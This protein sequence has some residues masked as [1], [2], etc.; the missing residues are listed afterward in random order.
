MRCTKFLLSLVA[1]FATIVVKAQTLPNMGSA[2]NFGILSGGYFNADDTVIVKGVAGIA[3]GNL[4]IIKAVNRISSGTVLTTALNDLNAAKN[5]LSSQNGTLVSNNLNGQVLS[6][7]VYSISGNASLSSSLELTGDSNSVFIFNIDGDLAFGNG[8]RLILQKQI[9]TSKIYWNVNGNITFTSNTQMAG[10]CLANGSISVSGIFQG[11]CGLLTASSLSI[12]NSGASSIS[13]IFQTGQQIYYPQNSPAKT[14]NVFP[15]NDPNCPA[16]PD[17]CN[18]IA[19]PSFE[20]IRPFVNL[21][22][23]PD[24]DNQIDYACNWNKYYNSVGNGYMSQIAPNNIGF[25]YN[26]QAELFATCNGSDWGVPFNKYCYPGTATSPAALQPAHNGGDNYAG[27]EFAKYYGSIV[28]PFSEGD[29]PP[30]YTGDIIKDEKIEK[31]LGFNLVPS[32]AYYMEFYAS[33]SPISN[34]TTKIGV[35]PIHNGSD[36]LSPS[37]PFHYDTPNPTAFFHSASNITY[38]TNWTKVSGCVTTSSSDIG[39]LSIRAFTDDGIVPVTSMDPLVPAY[40]P[41]AFS[42]YFFIDDVTLRP[43]ADA[44][45]DQT[46]TCNNTAIIGGNCAP[47]VGATYVWTASN[48]FTA[49]NSTISSPNANTSNVIFTAPGTFVYDVTVTY[50]GC[51]ATDQ[52]VITV[53][54]LG[55]SANITNINLGCL[56]TQLSVT[57]PVTGAVYTWQPGGFTGTSITV[58][59]SSPTVYTLYA[60]TPGCANTSNVTVNPF[61]NT[62][63]CVNGNTS[64]TNITIPV[65]TNFTANTTYNNTNFTCLGSI[66]VPLGAN[67][68]FN[69]CTFMMGPNTAIDIKGKATVKITNSHF[70]GC[71]DLWKGILMP[72]QIGANLTITGSVIEDAVWGVRVAAA[73]SNISAN[74]PNKLT[75]DNSIFN[76]NKTDIDYANDNTNNL[77]V[78]NSVFT[79][80]CLNF[81]PSIT[82]LP[83]ISSSFFITQI[84]SQPVAYLIGTTNAS[85]IYGIYMYEYGNIPGNGTQIDLKTFNVFDNHQIGIHTLNFHNLRIEKQFF[86]NGVLT[87]ETPFSSTGIYVTNS[88][89]IPTSTNPNNNFF[90]G[91]GAGGGKGNRFQN[92]FYGIYVTAPNK[93][94]IRTNIGYN[95]FSKMDRAGIFYSGVPYNG[96]VQFMGSHVI[97]ANSFFN[98]TNHAISV[99]NSGKTGMLITNNTI[100]NPTG[101]SIPYKG[102]NIS[103]ISNPS[104]AKYNIAGN[105]LTNVNQGIIASNV[106]GININ[107]NNIS[108]IQGSTFPVFNFALGI[109]LKNCSKPAVRA[110][111]IT[112]LTIGGAP[113]LDMGI[114]VSDCPQ[115]VYTCNTLRY[116][117]AGTN[118]NGQNLSTK[119]SQNTYDDNIIGIYLANNGF[120]DVQGNSSSSGAADNKF[121]NMPTGA[122][123]SYAASVGAVTTNG[124]LSPFFIRNSPQFNMTNNGAS[125]SP[126]SLPVQVNY[127]VSPSPYINSCVG[128]NSGSVNLMA[129]GFSP[130]ADKVANPGLYAISLL[131]ENHTSK[132][133]L[134]EQLV[135]TTATPN[136]TLQAFKA[137]NANGTLNDIAMVDSTISEHFDGDTTA[138]QKAQNHNTFTAANNVE[139][140]QKDFNNLY[141]RYLKTKNLNSTE[142]SQLK[143]IA[144]RCPFSDGTAV[145]QARA[146]MRLMDD[147]MEYD[148]TCE[149]IDPSDVVLMTARKANEAGAELG[150]KQNIRVELMPNPNNGEFTL[151]LNTVMD[152]LQVIVIDVNGKVVCDNKQHQAD[153]L[154][155]S[156]N[157]LA[158][159]LY[160]LKVF[161]NGNYLQTKKLL[162]QK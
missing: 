98:C 80:R 5:F 117:L 55:A 43:L 39:F 116:L 73:G 110:N 115:G 6:A 121:I 107:S 133:Q 157:S 159:G 41:N 42:A 24:N 45:L 141:L 63:N 58:N 135:N 129:G 62:T 104:N 113:K 162:I 38:N 82:P 151:L 125:T 9:R 148:N 56:G 108:L 156:C 111:D 48:A 152:E 72:G 149:R 29:E 86:I 28:N 60:S 16:V 22:N 161:G 89:F 1:V 137:A 10:L 92:L 59:P 96:S 85:P 158:N 119:L 15:D 112:G 52:V 145:W 126:P 90:V 128:N 33:L 101:T 67:V 53:N 2:A 4:N 134:Y 36:P 100:N 44:G 103:E 27:L 23:C 68:N 118:F 88:N 147:D 54:S 105:N 31:Y 97:T 25:Q 75:V 144:Q 40:A 83:A 77:S 87:K 19:N 78:K 84:A 32:K 74:F 153:K 155:L 127:I 14:A 35:Y 11:D 66:I 49:A 51:T 18:L 114:S 21:A 142:I 109:T 143:H 132:R 136:A 20:T 93:S 91:I 102:I 3:S 69:N 79:S 50:N 37:F 160:L 61:D 34:A 138:L 65:G 8:T 150:T 70:Y 124:N 46:L 64:G 7:G 106:Y 13:S 76:T 130:M 139:S 17:N 81:E 140:T 30:A 99:V 26:T 131:R 146:L 120:I 154:E 47:I 95:A 123:H 71:T 57:Y 12:F 94:I 122:Y